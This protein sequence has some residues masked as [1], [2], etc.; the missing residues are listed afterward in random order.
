[1]IF[2]GSDHGGYKLKEDLKKYLKKLKHEF[3]DVGPEKF[4]KDDDYP[5]YSKKV[6]DG[7]RKDLEKNKGI[8]I[9]RSGHGV[10][11]AANKA[12]GI[13]AALVW[14]EEVA[15]HSKRDDDAN[16]LCLPS[17]FISTEAAEDAVRIWLKT[18]FTFEER[19]IKRLKQVKELEK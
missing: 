1:M 5:L 2:I 17:D 10:C 9:C 11:I 7:V 13:R 15:K 6:T 18:P 3:V 4:V 8:L 12:K 16:V 14:N 19:H